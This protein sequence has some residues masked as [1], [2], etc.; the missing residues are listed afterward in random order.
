MV[1]LTVG[2]G[3]GAKISAGPVYVNVFGVW[4]RDRAGIRYGDFVASP[5]ESE[6]SEIGSWFGWGQ[7]YHTRTK[8]Q[9]RRDKAPEYSFTDIP[10]LMTCQRGADADPLALDC[11]LGLGPS[12]RLGICPFEFVD[13]IFGW[14]TLD[15]ARD[16]MPDDHETEEAE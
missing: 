2:T 3:L 12:V 7:S 13:F 5:G 1:S 8:L 6:D 11:V 14:T 4:H 16:D 15:L 10:F 9:E